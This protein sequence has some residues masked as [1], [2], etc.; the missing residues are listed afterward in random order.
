VTD[1]Q[2]EGSK[3]AKGHCGYYDVVPLF[4]S[5][6][7]TYVQTHF[8]DCFIAFA[9]Y[10]GTYLN[11]GPHNVWPAELF[12]P[13]SGRAMGKEMPV[14][15]V[16]AKR[17]ATFS[18]NPDYRPVY[19]RTTGG[20]NNLGDCSGLLYA[21]Q[22]VCHQ[23]CNRILWSGAENFDF[24]NASINWPPSLN[25]SRIVYGFWGVP[26]SLDLAVSC[27]KQWMSS[28]DEA[29]A[30]SPQRLSE[31]DIHREWI[32]GLRRHFENGYKPEERAK[33]LETTFNTIGEE[34]LLRLGSVRR[35]K[36]LELDAVFHADKKE[37]DVALL[38]AN[39][40][41]LEYVTQLNA[42][43]EA[44]LTAIGSVLPPKDFEALFGTPPGDGQLHPLVSLEQMPDF[45]DIWKQ[46]GL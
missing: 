33:H 4:G 26:A 8:L 24:F 14:D 25:F 27:M 10:G 30:P 23:M 37:L 7:H 42:K 32:Q 39:L 44:Y 43:F 31:H 11:P 35:A 20:Y 21:I 41:K 16:A 17:M 3:Y 34:G 40:S 28:P 18:S 6:H 45:G 12:S 22:G 13:G 46:M 19:D 1:L 36:I 5:A 2:L 9:C 38:Q 15:P 29:G